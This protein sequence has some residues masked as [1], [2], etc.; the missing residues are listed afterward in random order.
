M[1]LLHMLGGQTN[2]FPSGLNQEPCMDAVT[3]PKRKASDTIFGCLARI[4]L[5]RYLKKGH[6]QTSEGP[7]N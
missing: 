7:Q 1:F 4:Q 2:E 6:F 5:I 3:L